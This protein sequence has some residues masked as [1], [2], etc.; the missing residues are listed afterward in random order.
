MSWRLE[1]ARAR[2]QHVFIGVVFRYDGRARVWRGMLFITPVN[3]C[4][5]RAVLCVSAR[6]RVEVVH[7]T[8]G[9]SCSGVFRR[10]FHLFR[11]IGKMAHLFVT[12]LFCRYGLG[13]MRRDRRWGV[14]ELFNDNEQLARA[15]RV[16]L[17]C[18]DSWIWRFCPRQDGSMISI[19]FLIYVVVVLV[20]FFYDRDH[21]IQLCL[22][23]IGSRSSLII[24]IPSILFKV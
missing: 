22:I 6:F 17:G 21:H 9:G 1:E 3:R 15:Y 12:C 5:P 18:A 16:L 20:F 10:L 2:E 13:Q 14:S 24:A 4:F 19:D 11:W 7:V 8:R 23:I